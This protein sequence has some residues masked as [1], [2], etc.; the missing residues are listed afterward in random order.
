MQQRE[1]VQTQAQTTM[2]QQGAGGSGMGGML[3]EAMGALFGSGTSRRMS[4]GQAMVNSAAR[5]IGSQVGR[6]LIRGALGTLLGGSSRR[7]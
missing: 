4:P 7:R 3:N 1:K 2:Q 6:D 5:A